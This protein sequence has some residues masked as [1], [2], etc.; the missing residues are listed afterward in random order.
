MSGTN[1]RP[2]ELPGMLQHSGGTIAG[3]V[4]ADEPFP[5]GVVP[6]RPGYRCCMSSQPTKPWYD[7]DHA[8]RPAP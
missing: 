6:D 3:A 8:A 7:E 4:R 1:V 2:S 5:F